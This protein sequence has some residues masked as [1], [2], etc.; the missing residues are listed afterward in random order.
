M[1]PKPHPVKEKLHEIIFEAD[2]P[3]GKLFDVILLILILLSVFVVMLESVEAYKARWG[4]V[5]FILEWI[6][7]VIFT[8]EYILRLYTVYRPIKY[9]T[10]LF[11]IIDL[12]SILPAFLGIF[13]TG[14]HSLI[15]IRA[16]RLMRVFRIFKLGHF[17]KEGRVIVKALKASRAKITVFLSFVIL[18]VTIIGSVMYLIEGAYG[19]EGFSS[20]PRS[21]Y[22]AIVTLTT[23]GYGDITP[24]S[25]IGQF[26]SA[27]VMILGYAII[28][29]PTGIVTT[30]LI[31]PS[32]KNNTQACRFC[33]E[34][35]HDDDAVF[36]KY[37]GQ[38]L[39]L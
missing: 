33:G 25:E 15:V 4:M 5:F 35:G 14:A 38:K 27:L 7:T 19:N 16:L 23:V 29:V 22:W 37:C 18:M 10:S 17:L 24:V 21:M 36:C 2:T 8:I 1:K 32:S 39:N 11:G 9:A 20:I 34:E 13:F 6:F 3:E 28:A 30:E 26:L 12:L 31:R